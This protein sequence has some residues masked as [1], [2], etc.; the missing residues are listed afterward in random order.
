MRVTEIND[1][2]HGQTFTSEQIHG[3]LG[4]CADV[5][6]KE[7]NTA[8]LKTGTCSAVALLI[9]GIVCPYPFPPQKPAAIITTHDLAC[10]A[11]GVNEQ[12]S[13]HKQNSEPLVASS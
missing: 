3:G 7:W 5:P 1:C 10:S 4:Q 8:Q 2:E 9:L 12:G 11:A 13:F 6:H